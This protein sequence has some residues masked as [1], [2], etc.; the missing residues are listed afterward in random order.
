MGAIG[1]GAAAVGTGLYSLA[2]E[3]RWVD[4][5]RLE[6]RLP[7]LT[8]AFDG[9]RIVHITD[10]HMDG[11]GLTPARVQQVADWVRP[12]E[13]D[14]VVATGD[15]VTFNVNHFA[16]QAATAMAA[17]PARDGL[18]AVMG[19]HD[20][21][22]GVEVVHSALE[23]EGI[24]VLRNQVHT[25]TRGDETLHIAGTDCRIENFA[26]IDAVLG[27]LPD[28][29]SPA[30]LLAHEPDFADESA[31]TGRFDLQLSG[32]SHGGQ[33]RYPFGG[34]IWLPRLGRKYHSGQYQVGNMIQYTNRGIG[35]LSPNVRFNCRPEVTL[36]TLRCA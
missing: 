2:I 12:W 11:I 33:V 5:V 3:P 6:L 25:L 28:D 26:D 14:A 15:F 21:W 17:F 16:Q 34:P 23:K 31:P 20:H 4:T 9:Y 18:F 35:S 32:H 7:R 1:A 24:T 10:M 36:I 29:N 19:N 22:E 8:P 27:Q 13:P 30:V